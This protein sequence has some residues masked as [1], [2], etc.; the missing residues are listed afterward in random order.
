MRPLRQWRE[1]ASSATAN[2]MI[3]P[4][5]SLVERIHVENV[6]PLP[7]SARRSTLKHAPPD[8]PSP[9]GCSSRRSRQPM[10]ENSHARQA[11][12]P[13]VDGVAEHRAGGAGAQPRA[14]PRDAAARGHGHINPRRSAPDHVDRFRGNSYRRRAVERHIV[15][16]LDAHCSIG[17]CRRLAAPT[18]C[19]E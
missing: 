11:C 16:G 14:Q 2:T 7:I 18:A 6:K 12:R 5:R 10:A 4:L 3:P 19:G 9:R 13:C 15:G 17:I 8:R 1:S